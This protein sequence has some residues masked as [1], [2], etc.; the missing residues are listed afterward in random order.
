[1][2]DPSIESLARE[3]A[4]TPVSMLI[5]GVDTG[6]TTIALEAARIALANGHTPVL[7]DADVGNSTV[8]PPAC[9]GMRVFRTQDDQD[10]PCA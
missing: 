5:G 9:V 2:A 4:S 7:V 8:G 1:M 6:K 10:T 3:I